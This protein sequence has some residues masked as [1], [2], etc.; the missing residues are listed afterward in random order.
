MD[1]LGISEVRLGA[2]KIINRKTGFIFAY[3]GK[4]YG[5]RGIGFLI[6][7]RL[8]KNIVK[9]EGISDRIGLLQ[10]ETKG[11]RMLTLIQVYAPTASSDEE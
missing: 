5:Q 6:K 1:I 3:N 8:S 10:I 4:E 9:F 2:E 11:K 7:S